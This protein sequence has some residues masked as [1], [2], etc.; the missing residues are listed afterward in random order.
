LSS[1]ANASPTHEPRPF[2]VGSTNHLLAAAYATPVPDLAL[3][4]YT[5]AFDARCAAAE[6]PGTRRV[7]GLGIDGLVSA[8]GKA[9]TQLLVRD[10][11]AFDAL[12]ALLPLASAGTI[13]VL[14]AARR[15]A[16]LLS[17]DRTW[18]PK[19][20]MAMVCPDLRTVP[21]PSLPPGLTLRP[22]CRIPED[23]PNGVPLTEAVEA[24]GRAAPMGE[25]ATA[26]LGTYLKSLPKGPRLFAAVDDGGAVRGTSASRTFLSE[27][28]VFFVNT[29]P[30]WRRRGVGLSMTA[31][32]LQSTV[33]SGATR[34]S[35][36][37]SGLGIPLYR[38]LG[39]AAVGHLTQFSRSG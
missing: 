17:S 12:A 21:D 33:E 14:D 1:E 29:D 38:R 20:V 22:V 4:A 15:C 3:D 5:A 26:A 34:A 31:A 16:E 32:A 13:R 10:D 35:L 30:G 28:Y 6:G 19:A 7:D 37:A 23:P 11:R 18:T 8:D 24:A 36:D 25:V 2:D 39:F 27:A 9:P